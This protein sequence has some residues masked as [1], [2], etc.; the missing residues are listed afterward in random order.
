MSGDSEQDGSAG[1]AVL[2]SMNNFHAHLDIC[3]QCRDRPLYL[4]AVG[5]LLLGKFGKAMP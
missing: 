2:A 4:C 5:E 1:Q 3:K